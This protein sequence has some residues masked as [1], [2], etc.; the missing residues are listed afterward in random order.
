MAKTFPVVRLVTHKL[1][2]SVDAVIEVELLATTHAGKHTAT[3]LPKGS[4]MLLS[5]RE[6][7]LQAI[8][9]PNILEFFFADTFIFDANKRICFCF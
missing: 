6:I 1:I 9:A 7:L 8:F 5:L 3:V 2:V 4:K